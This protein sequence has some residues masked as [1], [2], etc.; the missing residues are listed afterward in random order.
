M[1]T[2]QIMHAIRKAKGYTQ[3]QLAEKCG[4]ATGT[5]QQYELNK[6]EPRR[7]QLQKI[8][9]ALDVPLY[10]LMGFDGSIRVNITPEVEEISRIQN[11]LLSDRENVTKE[12]LEIL[13][14]YYTSKQLNEMAEVLDTSDNMLGSITSTDDIVYVDSDVLEYNKIIDK[15]K[16]GDGFTSYGKRFISDY[17][18]KS[19]LVREWFIENGLKSQEKNLERIQNAYEHLNNSGREEAAKRIEELTEIERYTK[20][21]EWF[22]GRKAKD[23]IDKAVKAYSIDDNQDD[24]P[25][26]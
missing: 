19:P 22:K 23:E 16:S 24:P 17:I 5:I 14:K 18:D 12:E 15:Q 6:R 1:T 21:E 25:Q 4:L 2:G 9:T 11:K 10:K 26:E 20:P 13:K 3:K 8:A 7:E